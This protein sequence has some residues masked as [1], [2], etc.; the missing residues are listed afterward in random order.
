MFRSFRDKLSIVVYVVE[1]YIIV[2]EINKIKLI[3]LAET[4]TFFFV[5]TVYISKQIRLVL[6]NYIPVSSLKHLFLFIVLNILPL[7]TIITDIYT[8]YISLSYS[9][10][11]KHETKVI[12]VTA[13]DSHVLLPH[14]LLFHSLVKLYINDTHLF[15]YSKISILL[16]ILILI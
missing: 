8:I 6:F 3:R 15:H 5:S 4:K 11:Y 2:K 12:S 7:R 16:L 9:E 10:K 13:K 1:T 14:I